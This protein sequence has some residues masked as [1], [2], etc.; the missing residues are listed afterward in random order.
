MRHSETRLLARS[1]AEFQ[2]DIAAQLLV[3]ADASS[4]DN[5]IRDATVED[6]GLVVRRVTDLSLLIGTL[7]K[8]ESVSP[9]QFELATEAAADALLAQLG[10]NRN[11]ARLQEVISQAATDV[12]EVCLAGAKGLDASKVQSSLETIVW[13]RVLIQNGQP[14]W[15]DLRK[16]R[17]SAGAVYTPD[18]VVD[19]ILQRTLRDRVR[20]HRDQRTIRFLDPAC[21]TGRFLIEAVNVLIPPSGES[22]I[23]E[24]MSDF[25][26]LTGRAVFGVD[27]DAWSIS[28]AETVLKLRLTE[29]RQQ[30]LSDYEIVRLLQPMPNLI[31]AN[32]LIDEIDQL[33]AKS[34]DV[35]AG[36]PPY[37]RE[38]DSKPL[39]D[40]I[41]ATE[42]GRKYRTARMD[43]WYYFVHRAAELLRDGGRL[44]YIVN[45]Y[46]TAGAGAEKLVR[47]FR[48]D[49]PLDEIVDLASLPV[50][51]AVSGRHMIFR[52]TKS[53]DSS[54][55]STLIRRPRHSAQSAW[56]C[57]AADAFVDHTKTRSQLFG[58][59]GI[60]LS[61]VVTT[62]AGASFA[63]CSPL[64]ELGLIRQGIAENPAT[65]N[66]RTNER[67][68]NRWRVGDGV[69]VLSQ[70]E[71]ESLEL[72][73]SERAVLRPYH[74]LKDLGRY[75]VAAECSH[76]LI[77]S[78]RHTIPDIERYQSLQRHLAKFRPIMDSRRETRNGNNKWWHLHWPRDESLWQSPKIVCIQMAERPSF[79]VSR[80]ET[81]VSFSANVFVPGNI[82]ESLE[83]IAAVLNSDVLRQWFE[84]HAKHRGVRLDISG[85][86]LRLAPI[87]RID[88]SD[89]RQAGLHD[90]ITNAA[91]RMA[92]LKR[93]QAEEGGGKRV[94]GEAGEIEA[95]LQQAVANLYSTTK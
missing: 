88:F 70:V 54:S 61:P 49:L 65:I 93:K 78:T 13:N 60:D 66:R 52:A 32:A 5:L 23:R 51:E 48:D 58:L 53:A 71:Y 45:S 43:Y 16:R 50:F 12:G 6:F 46:W 20:Q 73:D 95:R 59:A 69:F 39:M 1:L 87:R 80:T 19:Y 72:A 85:G 2:R 29:L 68:G 24:T 11:R 7:R 35:I 74:Q 90:A 67:F 64:G 62:A 33:R 79:A 18:F 92:M 76:R 75:F 91:V 89:S 55:G 77:Y 9:T 84:Q 86:V 17:K 31:C 14:C 57:F 94:A 37:R 10:H 22:G 21:G 82:Q 15:Q 56:Q 38:R 83:Y 30:P 63:G 28:I 41:A 36:N 34:F 8:Q 44:S 27:S 40:E 3:G 4:T 26:E 25:L 47:A 42:F 81:Y